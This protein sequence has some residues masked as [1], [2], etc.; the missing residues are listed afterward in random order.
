MSDYLRIRGKTLKRG[1]IAD[2][3]KVVHPSRF[4]SLPFNLV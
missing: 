1:S 3:S 4:R 2:E